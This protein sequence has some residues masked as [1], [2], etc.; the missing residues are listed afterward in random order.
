MNRLRCQE[1]AGVTWAYARQTVMVWVV[2]DSKKRVVWRGLMRADYLFCVSSRLSRRGSCSVGLHKTDGFMGVV[3]RHSEILRIVVKDNPDSGREQ[4]VQ[5]V[6]ELKPATNIEEDSELFEEIGARL[7]I[8]KRSEDCGVACLCGEDR[9]HERK[10]EG[11]EWKVVAGVTD[12]AR[13]LVEDGVESGR[14]W[15]MERERTTKVFYIAARLI[16]E[17]RVLKARNPEA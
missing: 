1:K 10:R 16:L 6:D 11:D 15:L 3:E 5:L 17:L 4:L 8:S 12:G 13:E 9:V 7:S 14:R 2:S